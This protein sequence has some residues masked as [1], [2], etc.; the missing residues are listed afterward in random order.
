[1]LHVLVLVFLGLVGAT[2][3]PA[4][5]APTPAPTA[6]TPAPTAP[7]P[8]PTAPTPSPTSPTRSPTPTSPT[9]DAPTLAPSVNGGVVG[10]D[11]PCSDGST[12]QCGPDSAYCVEPIESFTLEIKGSNHL[13]F[14]RLTVFDYKN[15][16]LGVSIGEISS[17]WNQCAS[18][19][20]T[21]CA[22]LDGNPETC[23]S[24]HD[25]SITEASIEYILPSPTMVL[26]VTIDTL[27]ACGY[28]PITEVRFL[29]ASGEELTPW[30]QIGAE[31]KEIILAGGEAKWPCDGGKWPECHETGVVPTCQDGTT[32]ANS[33]TVIEIVVGGWKAIGTAG[34]VVIIL[35]ALLGL[36]LLVLACRAVYARG[37]KRPAYAGVDAP[38]AGN[39]ETAGL[40]DE[41][42]EATG[43]GAADEDVLL[44]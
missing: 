4:P 6:P 24:T 14:S 2:P 1:M 28:G 18:G 40:A 12:P 39:L 44:L 21:A 31:V 43:Y 34:Q 26:G 27:N 5:S 7:T 23:Y 35:G 30:H 36:A 17:E 20:W 37:N 9:A 29:D 22:T 38:S 19:E 15:K 32:F 11:T 41:A 8:A 42:K 10:G 25:E 16:K 3:T 13:S 33:R